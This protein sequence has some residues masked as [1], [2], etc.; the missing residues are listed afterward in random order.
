MRWLGLRQQLAFFRG[1]FSKL[2]SLSETAVNQQRR[3]QR[4]ENAAN[5]LAWHAQLESYLGNYALARK[6]CRQ[7]GEAS[8]DGDLGLAQWCHGISGGRRCD[9]G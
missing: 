9:A 1:D 8:K 2:R 4:M 6:L 5:E 3:A 7:A